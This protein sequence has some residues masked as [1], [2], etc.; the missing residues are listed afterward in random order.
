M[1]AAEPERLED[2]LKG[3][4]VGFRYFVCICTIML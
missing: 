2:H 1:K 3:A 4:T